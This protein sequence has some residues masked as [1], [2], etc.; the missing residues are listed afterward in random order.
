MDTAFTMESREK[1]E[2]ASTIWTVVLELKKEKGKNK[3]KLLCFL[4]T[5]KKSNSQSY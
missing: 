2:R 5:K 1:E 4:L 3:I